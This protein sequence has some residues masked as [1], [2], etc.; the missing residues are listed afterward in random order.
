[1]LGEQGDRSP[2]RHQDSNEHQKR[3]TTPAVFGVFHSR[4]CLSLAMPP[5][6]EPVADEEGEAETEDQLGEQVLEVEDVAHSRSR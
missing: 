3:D 5:P 6:G 4:R 2:G 1:M